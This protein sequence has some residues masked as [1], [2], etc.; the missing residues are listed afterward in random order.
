MHNLIIIN[1]LKMHFIITRVKLN[2]NLKNDIIEK[3]N[4]KRVF[5]DM[6]EQGVFFN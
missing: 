5:F 6:Q 4:R 2:N 1:N 3:N